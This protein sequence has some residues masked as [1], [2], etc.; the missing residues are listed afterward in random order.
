MASQSRLL[1]LWDALATVLLPTVSQSYVQT[2]RFSSAQTACEI[3]C[4]SLWQ[5]GQM[6]GFVIALLAAAPKMDHP[7]SGEAAVT[8]CTLHQP[9]GLCILHLQRARLDHEQLWCSLQGTHQQRPLSHRRISQSARRRTA[10]TSFLGRA[11]SGPCVPSHTQMQYLPV[12]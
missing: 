12:P 10:R 3:V 11:P 8:L 5:C 1:A 2:N 4:L 9:Q 7:H 6:N